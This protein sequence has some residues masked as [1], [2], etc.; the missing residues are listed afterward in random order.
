MCNIK[1]DISYA[2]LFSSFFL[3]ITG[4]ILGVGQAGVGSNTDMCA[5]LPENICQGEGQPCRFWKGVNCSK[6]AGSYDENE[7]MC[8]F[9]S[10]ACLVNKNWFDVVDNWKRDLPAICKVT[11]RYYR[12]EDQSQFASLITIMFAFNLLLT[13]GFLVFHIMFLSK[14][15]KNEELSKHEQYVQI[16]RW[17]VIV[18]AVLFLTTGALHFSYSGSLTD[19]ETGCLKIDDDREGRTK[20]PDE[21]QEFE[22]EYFEGMGTL[23]LLSIA[24]ILHILA[25][26]GLGVYTYFVYR[27]RDEVLSRDI[28]KLRDQEAIVLDE[29]NG[30]KLRKDWSGAMAPVYRDGVTQRVFT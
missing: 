13:I 24:G 16:N 18:L 29:P 11:E 15:L 23:A 2:I 27:Y 9:K 17:S 14:S 7:P 22:K 26:I 1:R 6:E 5:G 8:Q 10:G 12:R 19:E 3:Y 25:A 4:A 30:R 21:V 20:W 28:Q